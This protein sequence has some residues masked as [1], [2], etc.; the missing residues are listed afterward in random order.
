MGDGSRPVGHRP[1]GDRVD[2]G[3]RRRTEREAP[4]VG[5]KGDGRDGFGPLVPGPV[6]HRIWPGS[7]PVWYDAPNPEKD[8]EATPIDA[9][10]LDKEG[11]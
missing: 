10:Q 8:E 11:D 4:P 6:N 9:E 2:G 3:R 5:R 7:L 1:P